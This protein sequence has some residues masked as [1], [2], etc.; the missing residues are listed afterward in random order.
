MTSR[1]L[2]GSGFWL[3]L[4]T[5]ACND[6]FEFDTAKA[7]GGGAGSGAVSGSGAAGNGG[8]AG[9]G[10]AAGAGGSAGGLHCSASECYECV[11]DGD[12]ATAGFVRCD[13][14]RHRCVECLEK[15][16]C[17]PDFACDQLA[18]RC[19]RVCSTELKCPVT[20][21]GCDEGRGVCYECDEDHE[22]S[23]SPLG[24]FCSADG[25]GCVMC[26]SDEDCSG[27]RCDQLRGN[28]VDCRDG[29][30]CPSRLCEPAT[31][32]CLP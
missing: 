13:V 27:K 11:E 25:S 23:D 32:T 19:L 26:K 4:L 10:A 21:H 2:L 29:R 3:L 22:C 6:R 17:A 9:G 14:Q 30:D 1:S 15:S 5:S 18:N 8:A 12:C 7:G 28:C 24:P 31:H 20:A 16:D